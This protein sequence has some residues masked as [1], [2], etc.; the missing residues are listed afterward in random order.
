MQIIKSV[1]E[2]QS[3]CIKLKNSNRKI[4]FVP[5]MGFLHEGHIS[6]VKKAKSLSDVVIVSIFVNP[7][8]FAPNE[9]LKT[10]PRDFE[11]DSK[12]LSE[13][14]TDY[15][16]YPDPE[17]IYPNDFNTFVEVKDITTILEGNTRPTHFRGVTTILSILF[18]ILKPDIAVF[19]QKDAQQVAVVKKMVKDLF[20]DTQIIISE[21]IRDKDG[22][23]MS[24]RNTYL[25][26]NERLDALILNRTLKFIEGE[27]N[28]NNKNVVFLLDKV[29][30]D[31]IKIS[32][33]R[34]DY[35]KFVDAESFQ[36]ITELV[37]GKEYLV[38]I[39]CYIGK[40]RLIDNLI[41]KM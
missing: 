8:Q 15:I 27:V 21:I 31:I 3:V 40:T 39:A 10:Y 11:R 24:S 7:T 33:A 17:E 23:A 13:E 18:N 37:S 28:S 32:S 12:L 20:V 16:F 41:I 14:N 30:N 36:E 1:K 26:E 29:K 9:D 34:L 35:L 5:T 4:G 19:G 25:S 2:M 6:L 38:L 22:L